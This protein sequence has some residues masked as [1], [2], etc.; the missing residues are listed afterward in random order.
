MNLC[1]A[2]L[3]L[4]VST[5]LVPIPAIAKTP[6]GLHIAMLEIDGRELNLEHPTF[7]VRHREDAVL[8]RG[9][10]GLAPI[11]YGPS[12]FTGLPRFDHQNVREHHRL[13]GNGVG[14]RW[15]SRSR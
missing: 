4:T 2:C 12:Y 8:N 13:Q 5:A 15:D 7:N 6:G 11:I 1:C 14:I 3:L 9:E 10:Y